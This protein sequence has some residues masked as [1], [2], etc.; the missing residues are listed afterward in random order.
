MVISFLM[1]S[2]TV[3]HGAVV[4]SDRDKWIHM[5]H[6]RNKRSSQAVGA[7]KDIYKNNVTETV[8][9]SN[10]TWSSRASTA[11]Q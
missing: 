2:Y 4:E 8:S 9:A 3:A 10:M 5:T 7:E 6:R 1:Q 11:Q